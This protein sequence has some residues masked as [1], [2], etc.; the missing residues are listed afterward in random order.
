MPKWQK[1]IPCQWRLKAEPRINTALQKKY[2]GEDKG[3]LELI[4]VKVSKKTKQWKN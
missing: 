2:K 3:F 4:R 1:I